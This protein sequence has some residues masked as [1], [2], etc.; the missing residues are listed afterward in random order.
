VESSQ[1]EYSESFGTKDDIIYEVEVDQISISPEEV[2]GTTK[3]GGVKR[4]RESMIRSESSEAEYG[5]SRY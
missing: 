3:Y 1:S 4:S 2:N 5:K